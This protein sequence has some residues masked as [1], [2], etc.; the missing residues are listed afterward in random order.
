M[1]IIFASNSNFGLAACRLL[2]ER[3]VNLSAII[4]S[5]DKK[6]GRGQKEKPLPLKELARKNNIPV[7]E[8]DN[9]SDF[10][11]IIEKENPD[12]VVVAGF[13]LIISPKTLKLNSKL[14]NIHPSL[15]PK[16]RGPTPIQT[17]IINGNQSSGITLFFIDEKID[18]GPIIDQ[19]KVPFHSKINYKEAEEILGREGGS[20]FI[21]KLPFNGVN[22]IPQNEEEATYTQK[23][24][25]KDGAINWN[26]SAKIIERKIRAFNPWPGT[27]TSA[28]GKRFKILEADVQEQTESGPFGNPGK[29]YLGTNHTLAVQTKKDFLLIKKLQI[30]NKNPVSS[31]DFLQGNIG[32][33]GSTFS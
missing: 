2:L 31:K 24:T 20:F 3:E 21:E 8:A 30:E 32:F 23:I 33:I 9:T 17:S 27:Y 4:T 13:G 12:I 25:K 26:E 16:Y 6:I 19:K 7:K 1:K 28:N 5:S 15:L 29:I 10:H 22:A 11:F 18:H 14:I